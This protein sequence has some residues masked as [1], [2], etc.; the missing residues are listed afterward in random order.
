MSIQST[1]HRKAFDVNFNS[2][3]L[4][5]SAPPYPPHI[6]PL[7]SL[8]LSRIWQKNENTGILVCKSVIGLLYTPIDK[9][10]TD[11][12]THENE[13]QISFILIVLIYRLTV[14]I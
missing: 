1:Q 10:G 9:V 7:S 14:I 8:R 13:H 3:H 5:H 6:L 12:S 4:P 2:S 11:L